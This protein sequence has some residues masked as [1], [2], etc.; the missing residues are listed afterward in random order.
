MGV[1]YGYGARGMRLH[2]Y[3]LRK[4]T[5]GNAGIRLTFFSPLLQPGRLPSTL[6]DMSRGVPPSGFLN[7]VK[8]TMKYPAQERFFLASHTN[9]Q[10]LLQLCSKWGQVIILRAK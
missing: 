4:Q 3:I 7:T 8:S 2:A 9:T 6:T 1:V 5:E 10:R